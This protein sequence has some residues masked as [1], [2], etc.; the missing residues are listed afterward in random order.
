M[1]GWRGVSVRLFIRFRFDSVVVFSSANIT[2]FFLVFFLDLRSLIFGSVFFGEMGFFG[3]VFGVLG[4]FNF[5]SKLNGKRDIVEIA[6][7]VLGEL[8]CWEVGGSGD[9]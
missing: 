2:L 5:R 3:F 7:S 1:A 8:F 6:V 4:D 9:Y